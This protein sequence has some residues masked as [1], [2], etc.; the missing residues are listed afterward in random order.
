MTDCAPIKSHL[1][2]AL[3]AATDEA[4][5]WRGRCVNLFA[6]AEV[7][8]GTGLAARE[9]GK[10][11]PML[12]SQKAQRLS[13]CVES[14]A[15]RKALGDFAVLL[16]DRTALTHGAGRLWVSD[17]GNWLLTLDW[18]TSKGP[19]RRT[20]SSKEAETF[21]SRLRALVRSLESTFRLL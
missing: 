19:E 15:A 12:I 11:L 4:N 13:K 20:F 9:P 7:A 1:R 21:H 18:S 6:C 2:T 14:D 17:G 5:Q 8:I 10:K 16:A 3:A